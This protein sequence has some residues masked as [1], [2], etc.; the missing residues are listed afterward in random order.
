MVM[1]REFADWYRIAAVVPP[2][3]LLEQRWQAVA[4]ISD[5]LTAAQVIE[6][7]KLFAIRPS[8]GYEVPEFLDTAF[9]NHDASFPNHGHIEEMRVLAG[10]VLQAAIEEENGAAVAVAC[11]LVCATFATRYSH[12]TNKEHVIAAQ[13]FLSSR[14]IA[15]REHQVP[16]VETS[17]PQF[18]NEQIDALLPAGIFGPGATPSL[19]APLLSLL[20]DQVALNESILKRVSDLWLLAQA[21]R[22]ELNLLWW[23]QNEFSKEMDLPFSKLSTA[24]AAC[25]LPLELA[26]MTA[27]VPGPSAILG[28]I[29]SSL[30]KAT[31][32][33]KCSIKDAVNTAP[34]KWR[35][36]KV[37]ETSELST[38]CPIHFAIAKSLETDGDD[39]WIPVYKKRSDIRVDE[40][41]EVR[42]IAFQVYRERM[43]VRALRELKND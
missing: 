17:A 11:G 16:P 39:D 27:F 32:D 34:R 43:F 25:V 18:T 40:V 38:L 10:A 3:E 33:A 35:E 7:L 21:Q 12:L 28:L 2:S 13:K 8:S 29:V 15:I 26:D 42:D 24:Q 9:R 1:H 36:K 20:A 23:L 5:N 4:D 41:F 14:S 31:G 30:S 19:R 37:L 22:E 6:L